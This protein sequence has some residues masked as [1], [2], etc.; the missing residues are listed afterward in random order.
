MDVVSVYLDVGSYRAAAAICGVDPK[1][2][3]RVVAAHES[4][5]LEEETVRRRREVVKN[6]DVV[7]D[8]VARRVADRKARITAKR[9]LPEARAAGM[10]GRIGT[11]G[12]WWRR[13]R[14]CGAG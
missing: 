8:L 7:R 11:S 14:R 2:V 3:K 13:R 5:E 10:G 12:G 6:T 4:G 9:L 1:T